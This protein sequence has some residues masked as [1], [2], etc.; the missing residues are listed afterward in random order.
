MIPAVIERCAGIDVGKKFVV[1]CLMLGPLDKEPRV[2]RRQFGT[3]NSELE[4]LRKWLLDEECTHV[5]MESTGSYW[6]PVFQVLEADLTVVLANA[7]DVQ[8]RK[9]HKTDW[10]DCAWLA[11]LLRHGMVRAS[12]VPPRP[13]RE[14]RDLTRRRKQIV[15]DATRERNR[16]QKVL[17]QANVKLGSV[18]SDVFGVSGQLMLEALL[19]GTATPEQIA[20]LAQRRARSR[21]PEIVESLHGHCMNEHHVQMIRL[22]LQHLQFLEQQITSLDTAIE[23]KITAAGLQPAFELLQSLPGI[24]HD[25]AAAILAE[26]G[27]DMNQFPSAAQLSSWAGLCPGNARSAGKSKGSHTTHGNRWLRS[28]LVECA[29]AASNTKDCFLHA[30]FQRIAPKGRKR[31]LVC[32]AHALLRLI[33]NTL[34]TGAPYVERG[35]QALNET[36]R[37]RL[38][39]HHIR[40]LGRLGVAVSAPIP[41]PRRTYPACTA[42]RTQAP[43]LSALRNELTRAPVITE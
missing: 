4:G 40:R 15:Y 2:E 17:E 33:W 35:P 23:E 20:D 9:G 16:V 39:R 6:Q 13:I 10:K 19:E 14:L 7:E 43:E 30:R 22:S 21:I 18:L 28:T 24:S 37:R 32:I 26:T 8:P 29:W 11:H 42:K 12:F 41:E 36:Q 25:S 38:I 34:K 5:V 3:F 1:V 31:A 27:S